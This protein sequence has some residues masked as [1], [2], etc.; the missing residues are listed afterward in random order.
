MALSADE[1]RAF[2]E[3]ADR[4]QLAPRRSRRP[5]GRLLVN[6]GIFTAG[7]VLM[8]LTFTSSLVLGSA[9]FLMMV[10]SAWLGAPSI[11]ALKLRMP[12]LLRSR[13]PAAVPPGES[14][15]S[16]SRAPSVNE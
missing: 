7:F 1:Q 6:A 14:G 2:A 13:R 8:T 16:S 5:V 15:S 4:F 11:V 12:S 3:I 9:G 10:V